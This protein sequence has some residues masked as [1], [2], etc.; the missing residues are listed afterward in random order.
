[1]GPEDLKFVP[2]ESASKTKQE[3]VPAQL[4]HQR[5]GAG[6]RGKRGRGSSKKKKRRPAR[7]GRRIPRDSGSAQADL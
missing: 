2:I 4:S 7:V 5:D 3:K 6:M 1:V